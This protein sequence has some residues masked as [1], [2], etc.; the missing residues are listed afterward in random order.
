MKKLLSLFLTPI[1]YGVYPALIIF[2]INNHS[3]ET[4][5]KFLLGFVV[6]GAK[7]F[8]TWLWLLLYLKPKNI[9]KLYSR[10]FSR[11]GFIT[12]LVGVIGGPI[13]YILLTISS[14][15][16]GSAISSLFMCLSAPLSGLFEVLYL[17]RKINLKTILGVSLSLFGSTLIV[18]SSSSD[19]HLQGNFILG[20][21]LLVL[22]VFMWA[23]ESVII[24]KYVNV[25]EQIDPN[26][27]I[28]LKLTSSVIMLF[29]VLIPFMS[30]ITTH[31]AFVGIYDLHFYFTNIN[32]FVPI[33]I[34]GCVMLIA[35]LSYIY[36]IKNTSATITSMVYNL[37][38]L[39]T[40]LLILVLGFIFHRS[41]I[42]D[43]IIL[44]T[45]EFWV[46]LVLML[47]GAF[48]ASLNSSKVNT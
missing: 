3:L 39:V 10:I 36:C 47:S 14:F 44:H 19:F 6:V 29:V 31:N 13:G 9:L 25:T 48:I 7:E 43:T 41:Q 12:S 28:T 42:N 24:D 1:S 8:F 26:T 38:S 32:L 11:E 18:L 35:R 4:T 37:S 22:V 34:I 21:S 30:F 27:T 2:L 23:I 17:K 45:W 20:I 15:Y 40:P 46:A 33:F 5:N 16:V